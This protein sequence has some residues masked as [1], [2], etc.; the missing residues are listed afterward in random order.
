MPFLRKEHLH[1]SLYWRS[2]VPLVT[3]LS[4]E[5]C[6]STHTNQNS[7]PSA[8]E[9]VDHRL[10]LWNR[11]IEPRPACPTMQFH[12]HDIIRADLFPCT[13]SPPLAVRNASYQ[14]D[15]AFAGSSPN[16][17]PR[18]SGR[19]WTTAINPPVLDG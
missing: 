3:L 5:L 10:G 9:R 15:T 13:H 14:R 11:K 19:P 6:L 17:P 8:F 2:V 4:N 16:L 12:I 1:T 7:G 18:R